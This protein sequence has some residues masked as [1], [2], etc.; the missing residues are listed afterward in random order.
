MFE[1]MLVLYSPS[2]RDPSVA[3]SPLS[4]CACAGMDMNPSLS[5]MSSRYLQLF[6][7]VAWSVYFSS[8]L[9]LKL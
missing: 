6:M 2:T 8:H 9:S 3:S 7:T 4:S 1:A 5:T